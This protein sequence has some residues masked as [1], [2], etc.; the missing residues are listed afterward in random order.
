MESPTPT[1]QLSPVD[2]REELLSYL[3]EL[4]L[5]DV[6]KKVAAA[7]SEHDPTAIVP[8]GTTLWLDKFITVHPT[9]LELKLQVKKLVHYDD[10]VLIL[11]ETGTGKELI[12]QALHGDRRGKFVAVNCTSLPSELIE[13]ELFGHE[14]GAFTG[15]YYER[16]GKFQAATN[17][18]VF[19]DEIGDMPLA[20][21]AKLLRAI[22][23]KR[24]QKIGSNVDYSINARIV[25]ATNRDIHKLVEAGHF[26]EDLFYR[27]STF[28]LKTLPLRERIEDTRLISKAILGKEFDPIP[29]IV[30]DPSKNINSIPY[31]KGNVRELM[32]LL[33]RYVVLGKMY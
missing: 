26:R 8:Q 12:A 6:A 23:E 27:I 9:M 13:S 18:T 16:V 1:N 22:Q 2:P 7:I 20:M 24:A 29:Y 14:K 30:K 19:L 3:K 4:K 25:S 5:N 32:N 31:L 28:I 21:Q 33:R 17:G 10:P 15:A 11:G